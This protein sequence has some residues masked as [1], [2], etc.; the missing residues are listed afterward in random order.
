MKEKER[1]GKM[2]KLR[3]WF[4]S[5]MVLLGLMGMGLSGAVASD[6]LWEGPHWSQDRDRDKDRDCDRDRDKNLTNINPRFMIKPYEAYLWHLYK[7]MGGA[8][9]SGSP[10]WKR[11]LSFLEWK[12]EEYGVRDIQRNPFTYNRWYTTDWPGHG[13][14][15]LTSDGK[16]IKVG[17]SSAYSGST[18]EGGVTAPLIYYDPLDPNKPTVAALEGKIVVIGPQP[19]TTANIPITSIPSYSVCDSDYVTDSETFGPMFTKI[20]P[21]VS[22]TSDTW[23]QMNRNTAVIATLRNSKAVGMVFVWD[24]N[25][26][27]IAGMYTFSV[28]ALY[29]I[30]SLH[31]DRAEGSKVIQD[32]KNGKS[33]TLK[34]LAEVEP[35]QAYELVGYLPGKN[36]GTPA[37]EQIFLTTHTDGPSISQEDGALGLLGIIYYFAHIPQRERPRTLVVLLTCNHYLAAAALPA[38]Y[39]D[40]FVKNPNLAKPIKAYVVMEMLGEQEWREKGGVFEPT[41]WPET[42]S[43]W[44]RNNQLLVDLAIKAV[45]DNDWP[46]CQVKSPERPGIN[47]QYQGPWYGE[48]N[49][50]GIARRLNG[51]NIP[52]FSTMQATGAYWQTTAHIDRFWPD[53]YCT[54]VA[55]FCQLTGELM[56]ADLVKVDPVWGQLRTFIASVVMPQLSA[57]ATLPDS[58]FKDPTQAST[59]RGILLSEIDGIFNQVKAGKYKDAL[60]QLQNVNGQITSWLN[61]PISATLLGYINT[62]IAMLQANL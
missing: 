53:L 61:A 41:G 24:M 44:A 10:S 19:Y 12:L 4:I 36:Y 2:K 18:P 34:L 58:A 15:T 55:T 22:I 56:L 29:S 45:K 40:W 57:P 13:Q 28:P 16:R 47:G 26:D 7:D 31:L 52:G 49:Y 11:Y 62:G 32:A 17:N 20:P 38:D 33:A 5:S 27:R 9:Y 25:Y 54:Q 59:Q 14:W 1:R 51:A 8:T 39:V 37:D 3:I 50:A 48:G 43:V 35:T 46:R 21:E 30:P 6:E 23:Y 42:S 60:N